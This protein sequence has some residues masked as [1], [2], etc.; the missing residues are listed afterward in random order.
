MSQ[1][2]FTQEP[3]RKRKM[4]RQGSI[5]SKRKRGG[6]KQIYSAPQVGRMVRP[7]QR[8]VLR[9]VE[10]GTLASAAATGLY[11]FNMN[12]LFD[13][14]RTGTGSQPAGFDEWAAFYNR[15]IVYKCVVEYQIANRGTVGGTIAVHAS[16][17][18]TDASVA[19]LGSLPDSRIHALGVNTS[20]GDVIMGKMTQRLWLLNGRTYADYMADD[21]HQAAVGASPAE[22]ALWRIRYDSFA[23]GAGTVSFLVR[24]NFYA[25]FFDTKQ[26][27]LS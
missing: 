10:D 13:P 1:V 5:T 15:Y 2:T 24:L 16:N 17:A 3:S 23:G 20:G 27:A 14:N 26:L 12:S 8:V 19:T 6:R 7:R 4:S 18:D 25:E 9:Y 11:V 22:L 21:R